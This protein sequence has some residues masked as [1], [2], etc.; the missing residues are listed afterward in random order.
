MAI[1]GELFPIPQHYFNVCSYRI[2]IYD[3]SL[4]GLCVAS[5]CKEAELSVEESFSRDRMVGRF[6]PSPCGW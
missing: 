2:Y 5:Q 3:N 6:L 4:I 1:W